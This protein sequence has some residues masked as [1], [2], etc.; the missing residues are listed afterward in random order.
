MRGGNP[1]PDHW[2]SAD[3]VAKVVGVTDAALTAKIA[4]HL[5][6]VDRVLKAVA[7]ERQKMMAAMQ[8]GGGRP[9]QATMAAM[10]EKNQANQASV[11]AHLKAVRD[12]LS[13]EQQV[14]FDALQK[15][16]LMMGPGGRRGP[17]PGGE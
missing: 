17:P 4:P 16:R 2:L 6:E 5:A 13:P 3:S 10:R 1:P 11:D 8:A 15:P 9:D 14:K 7:E 12:L